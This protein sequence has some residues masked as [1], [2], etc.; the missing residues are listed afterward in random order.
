MATF[1][2]LP[3]LLHFFFR[4]SFFIQVLHRFFASDLD[5]SAPN[6]IDLPLYYPRLFPLSWLLLCLGS[7]FE[8][9]E[10]RFYY[11][12]TQDSN[13]PPFYFSTQ[14]FPFGRNNPIFSLLFVVVFVSVKDTQRRF[15]FPFYTPVFQHHL[16]SKERLFTTQPTLLISFKNP[17]KTTTPPPPVSSRHFSQGFYPVG[18]VKRGSYIRSKHVP[19]ITDRVGHLPPLFRIV[20][21]FLPVGFPGSRS[22]HRPLTTPPETPPFIFFPHLAPH[23]CP[24]LCSSTSHWVYFLSKRRRTYPLHRTFPPPCSKTSFFQPQMDGPCL[25]CPLFPTLLIFCLPHNT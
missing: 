16:K 21:A 10:T 17:L 6:K 11:S 5:T 3:F 13:C 19:E 25:N 7:F 12:L 8:T 2:P 18:L 9:E 23:S 24:P 14:Y 22:T 15:F 1:F 4:L 20:A